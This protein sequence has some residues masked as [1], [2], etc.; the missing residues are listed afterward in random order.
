M[1]LEFHSM[2]FAYNVLLGWVCMKYFK[3]AKDNVAASTITFQN[4]VEMDE[5]QEKDKISVKTAHDLVN[6]SLELSNCSP[7]KN[8]KPDRT[9]Q[10]EKRRISKVTNA[11]NKTVAI[12]T[13][14]AHIWTKHRLFKLLVDW[15]S[16][17]RKDLLSLKIGEKLFN[18]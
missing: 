6:K 10:T 9:L 12:S 16:W 2:F 11:F 14:W 7:L 17:S 1:L 18:F 15:L 3:R 5:K 13:W 4:E 8:I